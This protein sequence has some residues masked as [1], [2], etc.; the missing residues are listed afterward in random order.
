MP[1]KITLSD[2]VEH[3]EKQMQS[4]IIVPRGEPIEVNQESSWKEWIIPCLVIVSMCF[5]G[6]YLGAR[7]AR[8]LIITPTPDK[9]QVVEWVQEAFDANKL[10]MTVW[11]KPNEW[12]DDNGMYYIS[13]STA[14]I[15]CLK[16]YIQAN[17]SLADD[18][19]NL[20]KYDRLLSYLNLEEKVIPAVN[21]EEKTVL[22]EKVEPQSN[23]IEF[24]APEDF[25]W[26]I[27]IDEGN[28]LHVEDGAGT[29]TLEVD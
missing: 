18:V 15:I 5:I 28:Y 29:I 10:K 16:D 13:N 21:E 12:Q 2:R 11:S 22:Q 24:I 8:K 6:C 14:T 23:I 25:Q 9:S 26:K 17:R 4:P 7:T 1:K 20:T 19:I 27:D 3:L